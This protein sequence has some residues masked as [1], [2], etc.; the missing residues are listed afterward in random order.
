MDLFP[1]APEE[2]YDPVTAEILAFL[3]EVK[4]EDDLIVIIERA[5]NKRFSLET[6]DHY[7]K[8]TE[9]ASRIWEIKGED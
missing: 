3:P 8:I 7:T 1:G 4:S 6:T 5:F 9:L 2:E